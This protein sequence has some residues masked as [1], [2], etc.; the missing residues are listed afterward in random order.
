MK[1]F[2]LPRLVSEPGLMRTAG[3][4]ST[5]GLH[6]VSGI[7]VGGLIGYG[8][9][10]YFGTKP[11]WF[12]IFFVLGIGAGFRNVYLDMRLLLKE[13][14]KLDGGQSSPT[15]QSSGGAD[16]PE[17]LD[18][19]TAEAATAEALEHTLATLPKKGEKPKTPKPGVQRTEAIKATITSRRKFQLG[20][21]E[22]VLDDD[23]AEKPD[24]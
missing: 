20:G 23:V 4:A 10:Y 22:V 15:G 14:E 1:K 9:D 21:E 3:K 7:I 8:I 17:E 12:I 13:Q 24:K 11:L 6:M 18:P 19:A 2:K 16:E 5:I